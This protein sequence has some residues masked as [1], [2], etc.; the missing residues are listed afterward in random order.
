[1]YWHYLLYLCIPTVASSV[2]YY[3]LGIEWGC[4]YLGT[5]ADGM[6]VCVYTY[7]CM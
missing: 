4:E 5:D 6:Y 7:V 3:L 1:M 2:A